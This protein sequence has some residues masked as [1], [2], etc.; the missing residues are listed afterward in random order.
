M[1][2]VAKDVVAKFREIADRFELL[3]RKERELL[4]KDMYECR[5]VKLRLMA[6]RMEAALEARGEAETDPSAPFGIL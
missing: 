6:N 3:A 2:V 1:D 4:F 5:A